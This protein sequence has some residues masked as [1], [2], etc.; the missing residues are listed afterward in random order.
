ML[1]SRD[2]IVTKEPGGAH[3]LYER[4]RLEPGCLTVLVHFGHKFAS[5]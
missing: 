1:L 3:K 4:V 5:F 2:V